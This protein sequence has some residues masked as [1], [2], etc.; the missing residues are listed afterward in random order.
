[1]GEFYQTFREELT[2]IFFKVFQKLQKK[3]HSQA[4]STRLPSLELRTRKRYHIH[5]KK[6]QANITDE[7]GPKKF[8]KNTRKPN[9]V[10]H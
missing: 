6:L 5:R 7:H 2:L 10:A 9:P 8:Q 1:M 4:Y 3:E